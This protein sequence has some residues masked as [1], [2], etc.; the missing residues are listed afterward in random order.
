MPGLS[1]TALGPMIVVLCLISALLILLFYK[2]DRH[3][4][5]GLTWFF[6]LLLPVL[7]LIP[8]ST[9][10]A[11]RYLYLPAA[12]LYLLAGIWIARGI[13]KTHTIFLSPKFLYL[14]FLIPIIWIAAF[15][16]QA[17]KRVHIW[18]SDKTLWEDA[19][20]E[21]PRNYYALAY[22]GNF[23]FKEALKERD[24]EQGRVKLNEAEYLFRHA[25]DVEPLFAQAHVG[26]ASIYIQMGKSQD[27]LPL[28]KQ[29][30]KSNTEPL[31]TVRIYY[32]LGL[33]FMQSD[34]L[35]AAEFWFKRAIK[36]DKT[37][38]PAYFGLGQIY[39]SV[40]EREDPKDIGYQKAAMVYQ[41][42]IQLFPTEFK[43]YFSLAIIR[44]KEG[45]TEEAMK[46]YNMALSLPGSAYNETDKA[47]AHISLG[48]LYQAR[49]E[50]ENALI[51]YEAAIRMAPN[52]PKAGEIRKVIYQIN[53]LF[54]GP[55]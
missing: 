28:L 23:Y 48:I 14:G 29:A 25:L 37:F 18:Q 30:L 55:K 46:L 9:Q 34:R 53:P 45:R 6:I 11:D 42:M 21:E 35:K 13:R 10:M 15:G 36:E 40:A 41:K 17:R 51:H 39:T 20:K 26:L 7:N 43:A 31:L 22:L 1:P 38:K 44:G 8:T 5:F 49:M 19:L 12:G 52:H 24:N 50:Y 27:A 33:A 47:D 32:D 16:F 3:G 54:Q 4:F 2:K